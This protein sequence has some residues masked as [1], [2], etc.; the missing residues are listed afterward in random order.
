MM[1]K[2]TFTEDGVFSSSVVRGIKS[3]N[4][5]PDFIQII[6]NGDNE[7]H[8]IYDLI[9]AKK[10][11]MG[12]GIGYYWNGFSVK[13]RHSL[14]GQETV[15]FEGAFFL[16]TDYENILDPTKKDYCF[17]IIGKG[18]E[19]VFIREDFLDDFFNEDEI[20]E[21]VKNTKHYRPIYQ[22]GNYNIYENDD[23]YCYLKWLYCQEDNTCVSVSAEHL[24][25]CGNPTFP[26]AYFNRPKKGEY[27][28]YYNDHSF[29]IWMSDDCVITYYYNAEKDYHEWGDPLHYD[30]NG[31][32]FRKR[33]QGFNSCLYEVVEKL[34]ED[35]FESPAFNIE[36]PE[37]KSDLPLINFWRL[38]IMLY[39]TNPPR[40][41][42]GNTYDSWD[43]SQEKKVF[44]YEI[45]SAVSDLLGHSCVFIHLL[46][47]RSELSPE[48]KEKI[49]L[50]NLKRMMENPSDNILTII[51][52]A[53]G[54]SK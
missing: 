43:V 47:R 52:L 53:I 22:D 49:K 25:K 46:S 23:R 41:S 27:G 20:K 39:K 13:T 50:E 8:P 51:K 7:N 40:I 37:G 6:N 31:F 1:E 10:Q 35:F 34:Y 12:I 5:S 38:I 32:L 44:S 4:D 30:E 45:D 26:I 33:K 3:E 18:K 42:E 24:P 9:N 14:S 16:R 17:A 36:M 28:Y 29:I 19:D 54:E 21:I 11:H 2:F 15:P 48:V